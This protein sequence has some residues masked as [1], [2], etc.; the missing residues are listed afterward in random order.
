MIE[1]TNQQVSA[2]SE[3][4]LWLGIFGLTL[5]IGG[6]VA[7]LAAFPQALRLDGLDV[8]GLPRVHASING[9]TA[10]L[11]AA[12]YAAIRSG[13]R[14]TH[15]CLMCTCFVLSCLF[16]ISYVTYHSQA[17][18]THFGGVGWIRPAYFFILVT[19]ISLAPIL[20]PFVLFTLSRAAR[21]ELVKHRR[22]ARWTLPIWMYVAVTGVLV[23]LM[24][25]PYYTA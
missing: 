18:Q 5:L 1:S 21:G 22:L 12:G 4:S 10:L 19:H 24:M 16:L 23:Y 17:P 8:S 15:I 6:L 20:V 11:L 2:S 7:A 3:R 9:T 25:A 13:R 14:R